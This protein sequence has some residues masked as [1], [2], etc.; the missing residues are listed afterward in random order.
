[1]GGNP[2]P[3]GWGT[4]FGW[5]GARNYSVLLGITGNTA[6]LGVNE[7]PT[8]SCQGRAGLARLCNP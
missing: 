8:I 5:T 3:A 2:H 4:I 6:S 1:M 7:K